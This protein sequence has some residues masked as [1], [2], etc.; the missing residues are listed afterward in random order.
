MVA[1]SRAR[2][3]HH[4]RNEV[5]RTLDP[6]SWQWWVCPACLSIESRPHVKRASCAGDG[7]HERARMR[8]PFREYPV[9]FE[10][11]WS[12]KHGETPEDPR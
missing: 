2:L 10:Y 3:D 11:A 5:T 12:L 9:A 7:A 1:Y 8:G 6:H 4:R